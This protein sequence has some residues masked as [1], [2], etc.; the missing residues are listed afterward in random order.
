MRAADKSAL[1]IL[2]P[3]VGSTLRSFKGYGA[4][5]ADWPETAACNR[6]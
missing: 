3:Q 6:I 1:P 4:R 5:G 2:A